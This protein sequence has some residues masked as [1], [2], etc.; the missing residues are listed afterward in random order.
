MKINIKPEN[1]ELTKNPLL[2]NYRILEIKQKDNYF[3]YK[4]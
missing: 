2:K 3:L 4:F 1:L